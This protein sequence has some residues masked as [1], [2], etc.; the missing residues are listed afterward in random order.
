M[1]AEP[2]VSKMGYPQPPRFCCEQARRKEPFAFLPQHPLTRGFVAMHDARLVAEWI[3]VPGKGFPAIRLLTTDSLFAWSKLPDNPD[4]AAV[5]FILELLPDEQ[6][7]RTLRPYRGKGRNDYPPQGGQAGSAGAGRCC[8]QLNGENER[9]ARTYRPRRSPRFF[10]PTLRSRVARV[11][12][13]DPR[14]P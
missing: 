9:E 11:K 13:P 8:G 12:A 10:R 3:R 14:A 7:L 4:L 5:R 1:L 2:R 6:L